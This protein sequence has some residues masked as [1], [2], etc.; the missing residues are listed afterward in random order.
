[1]VNIRHVIDNK[2]KKKENLLFLIGLKVVGKE[3][4]G[5]LVRVGREVIK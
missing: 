4:L 2:I 1:M 5:A 3:G